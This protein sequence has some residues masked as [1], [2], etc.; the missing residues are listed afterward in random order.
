MILDIAFGN[1][2]FQVEVEFMERKQLSI[3]VHPDMKITA[4]APVNYPP[5]AIRAR[6]QKKAVWIARQVDFFEQFHPPQP[7]RRYV[8]GETHYYLGRQYRLKISSGEKSRVRL[9]GR[10]FQM[11]L[12]NSKDRSKARELMLKWYN[13]HAR[14]W[15]A[16][17]IENYL[18]QIEHLGA[19]RPEIRFRRM[20]KRWGSCSGN[21]KI[22][23]N[24]ELIKA[25]I[26]CIDYV[27][28]HELCHLIHP[29]HDTRFYRL[30]SRIMPDWERRKK[31]LERVTL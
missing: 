2:L 12:Q 10:F 24:T 28:V 26:H 23:L 1:R 27:I 30:L 15:L 18:P 6:L 17:R 13:T 22:V 11:E 9:I 21:G 4:K 19:S 20:Q 8:S 16:K 3:T 14:E 7:A 29:N 5:D 31:R 25:P